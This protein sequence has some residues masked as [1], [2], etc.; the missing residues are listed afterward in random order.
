LLAEESEWEGHTCWC[1]DPFEGLKRI[2]ILLEDSDSDT[3]EDSVLD[4]DDGDDGT[5]DPEAVE[6]VAGVD[7]GNSG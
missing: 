5:E 3:D 2:L 7:A 6:V 1:L 4:D